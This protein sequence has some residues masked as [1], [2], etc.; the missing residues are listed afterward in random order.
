M[1]KKTTPKPVA[2]S[3]KATLERLQNKFGGWTILRIPFSVHKVWGTRGSLRVKGELNGFAFRASL[4]PTHWPSVAKMEITAT[5]TGS[6]SSSSTRKCSPV[7]RPLPEASRNAVWS[8][9]PT[10]AP[11]SCLLNSS[12]PSAKTAPSVPGSTASA[13]PCGDGIATGSRSQKVPRP[14]CRADCRATPFRHG[15][16]A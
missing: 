6:T 8:R 4:L 15:S 16:G 1:K 14:P 11:R 7:R 5:Q 12:A 9:I 10:S 2:K 13:F 3:F